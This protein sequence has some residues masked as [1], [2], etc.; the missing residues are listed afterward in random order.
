MPTEA[1]R[2]AV[3]PLVSPALPSKPVPP[4]REPTR[5]LAAS[6]PARRQ[7]PLCA[8]RLRE[9]GSRGM[10]QIMAFPVDMLNGYTHEDLVSS[11]E[12]YLSELRC[13]DPNQPEFLSLSDHSK[14]PISLSTVGFVPLYG[15]EQTHKVLALFAPEDSLTAVALFLAYQWWSIDDIVRTS[16]SSREG[17]QQVK[18]VGERVVLYVLNRIIYRKNEMERNEIPFLC[19]SSDDY[20][21]IMW[22]KGEAIGFYSVKPAGAALSPYHTHCYQLPVLDTMFVR[23]KYRGKDLGLMMLEDFVESFTE[24]TLGLRYPL[25]SFMHK[26]CKHYFEKYPGNNDFLCEVEGAGFWFQRKPIA[27]VLQR[28][29]LEKVSQKASVNFQTAD[30]FQQSAANEQKTEPEAQ[31]SA[32]SQKDQESLD[33]HASTFEDPSVAHVSIRTRSSHLKRPKTGKNSQESG[34]EPSQGDEENAPHASAGRPEHPAHT[35][36][37]FEV[38]EE[39][40]EV[41]VESGEEMITSEEDQCVL[42]TELR[43]SPSEKL[44]EKEGTLSESLN[45]DVAEETAKTLV[46]A[47]EET[48]TEVLGGE[49]KLQSVSQGEEPLTLLVP[50]ILESPPKPSEDTVSEKVLNAN[51]SEGLTEESTRVEKKGIE[52]DKQESE[53]KKSSE[54]VIA[55]TPKEELSNNGLPNSIRSEAAEETVSENVSHKPAASVE[56]QNEEAEQNSQEAPVAL[57]QSS[58]IVVELEGVSFQQPSGQE[59]QK[60]QTEE[61]LDE[62][63]EQTE[64]Y[65]QTT[66]ERAADSSSEEAEIEVPVVD[67]RNLRRKAKGYKGPPKKK[68][69]PA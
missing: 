13:G 30:H 32:D 47:E 37:C 66:A 12:D 54:N 23:K 36:K 60:N 40:P 55:S 27:T 44:S 63:V 4:R 59:G 5:G 62:S 16:V 46:T 42:E 7:P 61:H 15:G 58:L 29:E 19:H 1:P 64:Q 69:K 18:S 67:R 17:L 65:T 11:A 34:P 8:P 28:E 57:G 10:E 22:R 41:D 48:A 50:L 9:G 38:I 56:D 14:I 6:T 3:S 49:S 39:E 51:D 35:P 20:A 26:A 45:G 68:G 31:L 33:D 25:S 24:D 21:K 52:E 43:T 2:R 53:E